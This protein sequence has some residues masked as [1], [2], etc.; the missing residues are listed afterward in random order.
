MTTFE[1]DA[2][3]NEGMK[4]LPPAARAASDQL[5]DITNAQ[6]DFIAYLLV[7]LQRKGVLSDSEVH[8]MIERF[9]QH[10]GGRHGFD[11]HAPLAESV[12][13]VYGAQRLEL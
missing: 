2:A 12:A 8:Q 1:N 5:R 3:Y 10:Y 11:E 6:T 13:D 9:R 4:D 7:Q